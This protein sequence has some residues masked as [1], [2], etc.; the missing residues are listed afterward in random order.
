[1]SRWFRFYSDAMRDPKVAKLS[2]SDFRLWT[3]LLS[4]ACENDGI[5][6]PLDDLKHLLRRRLDHLKRGVDRLIRGLLIEVLDECYTPVNWR[7]LQYISDTSTERVKKHR[8]KCNVSVTPPDTETDTETYIK[9][10]N[11][12]K[13]KSVLPSIVEKPVD[14]DDDVWSDF[15]SHRKKKKAEITQTAMKGI[16]READKAGWL[17]NDALIEI[18][19]RGWTGFNSDWVGNGNTDRK[20]NNAKPASNDGLGNAFRKLAGGGVD[21]QAENDGKGERGAKIFMLADAK[22]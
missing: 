9:E 1:M 6:P 3:E 12:K 7:K 10:K 2:D 16:L 11:T 21:R 18:V 17:L 14:V 5:I 15:I 22:A 19:A 4:I 8:A 13:E 20:V